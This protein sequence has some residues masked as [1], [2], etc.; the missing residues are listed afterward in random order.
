MGS[1]ASGPPRTH[2]EDSNALIQRNAVVVRVT[3]SKWD[4]RLRVAGLRLGSWD[5]WC[6]VMAF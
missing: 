2:L 6:F 4:G 1:V 3:Q 5:S